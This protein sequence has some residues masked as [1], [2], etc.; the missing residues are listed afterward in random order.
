M[1]LVF[2]ITYVNLCINSVS[3]K[4]YSRKTIFKRCQCPFQHLSFIMV[5]F[6][7]YAEAFDQE[8]KRSIAHAIFN[9]SSTK[10]KSELGHERHINTTY[11]IN[12]AVIGVFYSQAVIPRMHFGAPVC[13]PK[14]YSDPHT[15]YLLHLYP[16]QT[17]GSMRGRVSRSKC[18][19][20]CTV[21][22]WKKLAWSWKL[23]ILAVLI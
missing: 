1:R 4:T 21:V 8:I 16:S 15:L 7:R 20:L 2:E 14:P 17:Q 5:G 19:Y 6:V 12:R 18:M 3:S 23:T 13:Q 22:K 9:S 11:A 10:E